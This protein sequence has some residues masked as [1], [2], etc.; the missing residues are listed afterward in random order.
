MIKKLTLIVQLIAVVAFTALLSKYFVDYKPA[1]ILFITKFFFISI[2][3]INIVAGLNDGN[4][5]A[6][7]LLITAGLFLIIMNFIPKTELVVSLSIAC[8]ILPMV[9]RFF[10]RRKEAKELQELE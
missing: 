6:K 4:R 8:L 1:V 9:Y 5:I 10:Q 3:L 7:F 2:G